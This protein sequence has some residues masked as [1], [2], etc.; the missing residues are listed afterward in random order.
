MLKNR[1]KKLKQ[2]ILASDHAGFDLKEVI[3]EL[4]PC[5]IL[6]TVLSI[7]LVLKL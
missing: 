1:K 6:L 5:F 7:L 2:I 4:Y 3:K